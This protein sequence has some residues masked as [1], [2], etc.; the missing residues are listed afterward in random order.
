MIRTDVEEITCSQQCLE[1]LLVKAELP[2]GSLFIR[3]ADETNGGDWTWVNP[4]VEK[5][6]IKIGS[7]KR[8]EA[9]VRSRES[10]RSVKMAVNIKREGTYFD[11]FPMVEMT[12]NGN[13]SGFPWWWLVLAILLVSGSVTFVRN[14]KQAQS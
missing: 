11:S 12:P 6:K 5:T 13:G 2:D 14:R 10:H 4:K 7:G 1:D 9:V 3:I 8:L